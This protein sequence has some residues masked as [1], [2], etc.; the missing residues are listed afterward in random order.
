MEDLLKPSIQLCARRTSIDASVDRACPC[1]KCSSWNAGTISQRGSASEWNPQREALF[2]TA[3]YFLLLFAAKTSSKNSKGA[4]VWIRPRVVRVTSRRP[5]GRSERW[6]RVAVSWVGDGDEGENAEKRNEGCANRKR[7]WKEWSKCTGYG[8]DTV[9]K[10][11][12]KMENFKRGNIK[13]FVFRERRVDGPEKV[14][15]ILKLNFF[16]PMTLKTGSHRW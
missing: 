4:D 14:V 2:S 1:R 12:E 7:G 8:K 6:E 13:Y 3:R 10:V 5:C 15:P 11:M 9:E 16:H